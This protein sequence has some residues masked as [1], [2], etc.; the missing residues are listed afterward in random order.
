MDFLQSDS[1]NV[2]VAVVIALIFVVIVSA[3]LKTSTTVPRSTHSLAS[4]M[5][6]L[7]SSNGVVVTVFLVA[8]R[9]SAARCVLSAFE[10]ATHPNNVRIVLLSLVSLTK[11]LYGITYTHR[12]NV[13]IVDC[14]KR[15]FTNLLRERSRLRLTHAAEAGGILVEVDERLRFQ[16][17]WDVNIV[18]DLYAHAPADAVLTAMPSLKHEA[19]FSAYDPVQDQVISRKMHH[20]PVHCVPQLYCSTFFMASAAHWQFTRTDCGP[21][22]LTVDLHNA[23]RALYAPRVCPVRFTTNI[24]QNIPSEF[25]GVSTH[26]HRWSGQEK[27]VLGF[28]G[29]GRNTAGL[30][31]SPTNA[32]M[33][34]KYG[35]VRRA[36]DMCIRAI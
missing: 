13:H 11:R 33:I 34:A 31:R 9:P 4:P 6:C 30:S 2:L 24:R 27:Q 25:V 12:N 20:I 1:S 17:G 8:M 7:P 16:A 3:R 15:N 18:E 5:Q 21:A 29:S 22:E 35:S 26:S 19:L 10:N 23:R 28:D 36:D 32:E 14:S